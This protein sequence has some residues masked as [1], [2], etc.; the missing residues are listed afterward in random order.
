MRDFA[1]S[2]RRLDAVV[3]E[4][5]ARAKLGQWPQ[6]SALL[7]ATGGVF[8]ANAEKIPADDRVVRGQ[9]LLAEALLRQNKLGKAAEVLHSLASQK[10]APE[11]NWQQAQLLCHVQL[12]SGDT[13]AALASTT[14]LI[15]LADLTGQA[16]MRAES[17]VEQGSILERMGRTGGRP[18]GVPGKSFDECAGRLATAGDFENRGTGRRANEIFGRRTIAGKIS[19]AISRIR[20]RRTWRG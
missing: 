15:R 16:G 9:L 6:V 19:G 3:N 1:D 18:G 17:V 20:L 11:L 2:S 13:N 10:L 5:A 7:Q 4:A 8:Q 14:N 12:A